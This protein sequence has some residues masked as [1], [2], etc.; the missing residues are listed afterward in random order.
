MPKMPMTK[1]RCSGC[2]QDFYNGNNP[3]EIKECWGFHSAKMSKRKMVGMNDVPPWNW[4]ASWY[5]S[6][7]QRKG[8]IFVNCNNGDRTC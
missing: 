5:P 4:K 8:Y 6:C 7:Y 1:H 2:E 3:L